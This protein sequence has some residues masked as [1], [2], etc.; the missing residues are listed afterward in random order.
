MILLSN[1]Y[2]HFHLFRYILLS[3]IILLLLSCISSCSK[4]LE[5][6][7]VAHVGDIAINVEEFNLTYQYNPYLSRI[8]NTEEAKLIHLQTLIAVKMIAQEGYNKN[9]DDKSQIRALSKQ[10]KREAM[11]ENLWQVEIKNN[12]T[13]SEQEVY[14]AYLKSK[15]TRLFKYLIFP[16]K[17]LAERA[18]QHLKN[19]MSFSDVAQINGIEPRLIPEDSVSFGSDLNT[20]ESFVFQLG[21]NEIGNPLKIGQY[22]FI[23]KHLDDNVDIF[24]SADDFNKEYKRIEKIIRNRKQKTYF[25]NYIKSKFNSPPYNLNKQTFKRLVQRLEELINVKT[26][27]NHSENPGTMNYILDETTEQLGPF[28]ES[29]V[30]D[31]DRDTPWT[32]RTLL[33][34]LQVSP[35]P[36]IFTSPGKFRSSMIAATKMLLD[37]QVLVS[38]ARKADLEKSV[39][40]QSQ[41]RM[42][43]D[44]LVFQNVLKD[45]GSLSDT[46]ATMEGTFKLGARLDEYLLNLTSNYN[47][48]IDMA[49]FDSLEPL[50]S[51]MVVMKTHFPQR[52]IAPVLIPLNNTPKF[53]Q[54]ISTKFI[55]N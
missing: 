49:V 51:D 55:Q 50:K 28:L 16:D 47:I 13:V 22:F 29:P 37:D 48:S 33:D 53:V 30:V 14:E 39:F 21:I 6:D 7:I 38:L 43:T 15:R 12:I 36:L 2:T 34:R 11:I 41:S 5:T 44:Y 25:Q 35:Y 4:E 52:V 31:F 9:Y 54:Y 19:G 23:I 24:T 17:Q 32:V 26:V 46:S 40:V 8:Q 20:L 10:F 27:D 45:F 42:W 3:L 18:Y 1:I